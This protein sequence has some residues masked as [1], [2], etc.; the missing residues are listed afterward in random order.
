MKFLLIILW[1]LMSTYGSI[2][3]EAYV[4]CVPFINCGPLTAHLEV[5]RTTIIFLN[6][7]SEETRLRHRANQRPSLDLSPGFRLKV[8]CSFHYNMLLFR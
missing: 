1:S 7:V 4:S 5:V 8:L 3:E 2:V 6:F